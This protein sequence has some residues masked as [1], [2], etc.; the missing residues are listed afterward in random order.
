MMKKILL[1]LMWF[2]VTICQAQVKQDLRVELPAEEPNG[3]FSAIPF[4]NEGVIVFRNEKISNSGYRWVFTKMD[5]N[6]KLIDSTLI[7]LPR[8]LNYTEYRVQKDR[9]ALLFVSQSKKV[10]QVVILNFKSMEIEKVN[11]S[12]ASKYN[13]SGICLIGNY[14]LM[15][16]NAKRTPMLIKVNLQSGVSERVPMKVPGA[17]VRALGLETVGDGKEAL[18]YLGCVMKSKKATIQVQHLSK[19][20]QTTK[21]YFITDESLYNINAIRGTLLAK[22]RVVFCGTYSGKN[23][24]T[25]AGYFMASFN[26]GKREFIQYYNFLDLENFSSFLSERQQKKI[27]RKK[28]RKEARGKTMEYNSLFVPHPVIEHNNQYYFICEF[29]Y[30]TYYTVTT[31]TYVNGKPSTTTRTYFDGY[32]YTHASLI[33]FDDEGQKLWDNTFELFPAFKPFSV[34]S[35]VALNVNK[36]GNADLMYSSRDK[37]FSKSFDNNGNILKEFSIA[38]IE[39]GGE[40]EKTKRSVSS[41]EYWYDNHFLIYGMQRIKNRDKN[42]KPRKRDVFFI[43]KVSQE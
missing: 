16:Q 2:T 18:L 10:F 15:V 23:T 29:Y 5:A 35:F 24:I 40:D 30:P 17:R 8:S 6:L 1:S 33:C 22:D 37:L 38:G 3:T 28:K 39:T 27:D 41:I 32:Q 13:I 34:I 20:G 25:G 36:E 21:T 11:G 43:N 4:G 42:E 12:L 9:V 26:N 31:T 14:V 7:E 19:E